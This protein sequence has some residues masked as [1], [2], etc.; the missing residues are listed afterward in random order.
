MLRAAALLFILTAVAYASMPWWLPTGMIARW[1]ERELSRQMGTAVTVGD[2][3]IGWRRGLRIE[4]ITVAN[5]PGFGDEPLLT[6]GEVRLDFSPIRVVVRNRVL[7]MVVE[8]PHLRVVVDDAG[9]CNLDQVRMP[10]FDVL[11]SYITVHRATATL[12]MPGKPDRLRLDVNDAQVKAGPINQFDSVSMTGSL[13][14]GSQRSS[15]ALSL[16][17][18]RAAGGAKALLN[19]NFGQLDLGQLDLVDLLDL[20]LSKLTGLCQGQLRCPVLEDGT[21]A[22]AVLDVTISDLDLQPLTGPELPVIREAGL[23]LTADIDLPGNLVALRDIQLRAPGVPRLNGS[24]SFHTALL[25]GQWMG[26]HEL[27]LAGTVNPQTLSQL[28]RGPNGPGNGDVTVRG[29]VGVKFDYKW[30]D[31]QIVASLELDAGAAEIASAKRIIKPSGQACRTEMRATCRPQTWKLDVVETKLSLGGNTF[32]GAGALGNVRRLIAGWMEPEHT[33]TME[34]VRRELAEVDW[35]GQW[36][37]TDLVSLRRL[38]PDIEKALANVEL[39]GSLTGSWS[40]AHQNGT[41]LQLEMKC[42]PGSRLRAGDWLDKGPDDAL[43]LSLQLRYADDFGRL[44]E[45]LLVLSCGKGWLQ[46]R[47]EE[48]RAEPIGGTGETVNDLTG[49]FHATRIEEFARCFPSL[50]AGEGQ[51]AGAVKG[52]WLMQFGPDVLRG[53]LVCDATD[54]TFRV[55]DVFDKPAGTP[56]H[57]TCN[58]LRD[59]TEEANV[60]NLHA[61]GS[62]AEMITRWTGR[63]EQ[64]T[65]RVRLNVTDAAAL[66]EQVPLLTAAK[67]P[68]RLSGSCSA[69]ADV[70]GGD[71][72][73]TFKLQVV[74]DEL[75]VTVAP[76]GRRKRPG[77]VLRLTGEG[78]LGRTDGQTPEL[79]LSGAVQ[80]GDS[81]A[82]GSVRL[83]VG[84]DGHADS[85]RWSGRFDVAVDDDL[86]SIAPELRDAVE[87]FDL[88]GRLTG[89]GRVAAMGGHIQLEGELDATDL[90]MRVP[91]VI[92]KPAGT[93]GRVQF[94]ATLPADQSAVVV[95]DWRAW[96]GPIEAMGSAR[97]DLSPPSPNG[98]RGAVAADVQFRAWTTEA[99]GLAPLLPAVAPAAPRG[100]VELQGR[101]TASARGVHLHHAVARL[102]GLSLRHRGRRVTLDGELLIE[103]IRL[104]LGRA[105]EAPRPD[106]RQWVIGEQGPPDRPMRLLLCS[107][108]AEGGR[109]RRRLVQMAGPADRRWALTRVGRVT[110]D[111]LRVV[112]GPTRAT[113]VMDLRDLLAGPTGN[114]AVLAEQIDVGDITQ[115]LSDPAP[116]SRPAYTPARRAELAAKIEPMLALLADYTGA[117]DVTFSVEVDTLRD[118]PDTKVHQVYDVA[119]LALSGTIA[120]GRLTMGYTGGVNG[121]TLI[122]RY[123]TDL[124]DPDAQLAV[125]STVRDMLATESLQPQVAAFFPGNEVRGAMWR[126]MQT[127]SPLRDVIINAI[128]PRHPVH[129]VGTCKTTLIEGVTTGRAAP[130][131]VAR[132]FPGLNLVE[133]EYEKMVGFSEYHAD[134]SADND[135]IFDGKTYDLYIQGTTDANQIGRYNVGVIVLGSPQSAE[136]NHRFKQGRIPVLKFSAL[137]ADGKKIDESITYPWPNETVFTIFLKNNYFYRLWLEGRKEK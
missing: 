41:V 71:R 10:T 66:T 73:A 111:G 19:F 127:R 102:D 117:A 28:F 129:P 135:M 36:V 130:R 63:P 120:A 60:V 131:F 46:L 34:E 26:L 123:E 119:N 53:R 12:S 6:T 17:T 13:T 77:T 104:A 52:D 22:G 55:G 80:F 30:H 81:S 48:A 122:D 70:T 42:L 8:S 86:L 121:G 74:A 62:G 114:L 49:E 39:N 23:R 31:K 51:L 133:Y 82:Q 97:I 27:H 103:Q 1:I 11:T 7:W 137:I 132:V 45:G 43:D 99:E 136:W 32:E 25:A 29:D 118:W 75:D 18:G 87:A 78:R 72:S 93:P 79:V 59:R 92:V 69:I 105:A 47:G 65:A 4:S 67:H 128:E 20:P 54:L 115:W 95:R 94:A 106:E 84:A 16:L 40:L 108:A 89:R 44:T 112:A 64:W 2:L 110:T 14:H 3:S 88:G 76:A 5:P 91:G 107:G 61:T 116:V 85:I 124:T 101:V 113:L 125:N 109:T 9:Q 21:I 98:R 56:L 50:A 37:I 35:S 134:G 38:A 24:A 68:L 83:L 126:E 15:V 96:L 58:W 90:S 33:W 100:D 57:I